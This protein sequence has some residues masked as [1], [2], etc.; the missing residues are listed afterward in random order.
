MIIVEGRTDKISL[1]LALESLIPK[2]SRLIFSVVNGDITSDDSV[3]SSNILEK[4]QGIMTDGGRN[5]FQNNDYQEVIH[6][7]DLD[8]AFVDNQHIKQNDSAKK[9]IYTESEI[10][11]NNINKI[12]ARNKQKSNLLG[13]LSSRQFIRGDIPY[14]VFFF[15]SNL[16][17]VLHNIIDV[18]DNEKDKYANIFEEKYVDNAQEFVTFM[19]DSSFSLG[20]DTLIVGIM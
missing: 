8:G 15:S 3:N 12:I 5:K 18:V 6:L 16:E 10:I 2:E 7:V 20:M 19:C 9:T 13:M 4:I 1:E 17:H 14:R 11:T